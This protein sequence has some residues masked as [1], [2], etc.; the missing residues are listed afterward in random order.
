MIFLAFI[1]RLPNMA[2][3]GKLMRRIYK[4]S[5]IVNECFINQIVIDSHYELKHS[6]SINDQIILNL[7]LLLNNT[8]V[9]PVSV[10]D[11]YSYFVT[12]M[13]LAT[14]SYRLVWLYERLENYIGIINAYR[15]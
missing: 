13:I 7:V 12:E 2:T 10:K 5:L 6:E 14:K 3:W 1:A 15:V 9:H 11:E 8:Y 4:V